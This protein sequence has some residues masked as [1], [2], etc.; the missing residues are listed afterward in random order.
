[1][2]AMDSGLVART[3]S[4]A[5][6]AQLIA[7]GNTAVTRALQLDPR[8][9]NAYLAASFLVPSTQWARREYFHQRS[10]E[11]RDSDCGCE[12]QSYA[13][14]LLDLGRP[15]EAI[16][17][18]QRAVDMEP[19][20][21]AASDLLAI[22]NYQVGNIAEADRI[23]AERAALWKGSSTNLLWLQALETKR[24]A[25]AAAAAKKEFTEPGEAQLAD[26]FAALASKSPERIAAARTAVIAM[27]QD[28]ATA[29]GRAVFLIAAG[30]NA[31]ALA[32]LE[33]L[34]SRSSPN[35]QILLDIE[36][37]PLRSDPRWVALVTKVG[38]ID[39]WRTSHKPPELCK[40]ANAPPFCRMI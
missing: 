31:D 19:T 21:P 36:L 29:R 1:M 9:A 10:V 6:K 35:A 22:A 40:D 3:A 14:F 32:V 33:P 24:W 5:A 7:S 39:Y 12:H 37:A 23:V 4:G 20:I 8:N 15:S 13:L 25:D 27:P 38:L 17:Q 2:M 18:A 30:D 28:E 11:V 34:A 26:A 16:V